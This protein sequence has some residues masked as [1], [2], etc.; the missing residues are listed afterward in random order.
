MRFFLNRENSRIS[1]YN[2]CFCHEIKAEITNV[3]IML[4]TKLKYK[5]KHQDFNKFELIS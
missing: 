3:L 5:T 2:I 4:L 1:S